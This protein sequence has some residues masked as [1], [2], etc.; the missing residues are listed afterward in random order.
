MKFLVAVLMACVCAHLHAQSSGGFTD[1]TKLQQQASS[2]DTTKRE[3]LIVST[4]S[5]D[6]L[7]DTQR[8]VPDTSL[9]SLH[10]YEPN[11]SSPL[12]GHLGGGMSSSFPFF[13]RYNPEV[14]ELG[15]R[16]HETLMNDPDYDQFYFSNRDYF[17]V[18]Y[19][20]GQIIGGAHFDVAF[21][22]QFARQIHLNIGY[23]SMTDN[24]FLPGQRQSYRSAD[25]KLLQRSPQGN[26]ITYVSW[27]NPSM[28]EGI[29]SLDDISSAIQDRRSSVHLGNDM[30]ISDKLGLRWASTL[31]FNSARYELDDFSVSD[32]ESSLYPTSLDTIATSFNYQ[33]RLSDITWD[34]RWTKRDRNS[35]MSIG[36]EY[37]NLSISRD[38]IQ[39]D[40]LHGLVIDAKYESSISEFVFGRIG[41]SKGLLD[42]SDD[43]RIGLH[44]RYAAQERLSLATTLSY[45]R[46]SLPIHQRYLVSS[47]GV[48][49]GFGLVAPSQ[50][51]L[52]S[53]IDIPMIGLNVSGHITR[54]ESLPVIENL[55]G[56]WVSEDMPTNLV[57][58]S[59]QKS[60]A[61]GPLR[62]HHT[63]ALQQ[64]SGDRFSRPGWMYQGNLHLPMALFGGPMRSH[65]GVDV[66]VVS[67]HTAS[68]FHPLFGEWYAT[69]ANTDS[70]LMTYVNPYLNVD[71]DGFQIYLKGVNVTSRLAGDLG[72]FAE[73]FPN[74]DYRVKFG[75]RWT[76]LD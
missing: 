66:Y 37:K 44:V 38:T 20:S 26:R 34:N 9:N 75:I 35:E 68:T 24:G 51:E 50:L 46:C 29:Q 30:I 76:L 53:V 21:Y 2:R 52:Q 15:Q 36:L 10:L 3:P 25:I 4:V 67:D 65:W 18:R 73:G 31:Q 8:F 62:S 23:Q 61:L 12:R 32:R 45:S 7:Y 48:H 43:L 11:F 13:Y 17:N 71:V 49:D 55:T 41:L 72:R 19:T 63:I 39:V 64:I 28:D 70:G 1:Y 16:T 6:R 27:H 47:E 57:G 59:I 56:S 69:P 33:N 22:K 14:F 74:Y 60:Q 5:L 58:I 54:Y 42:A 40:R